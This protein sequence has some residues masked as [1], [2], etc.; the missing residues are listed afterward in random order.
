MNKYNILFEQCATQCVDKHV[1]L[2]PK[3]FQAMK[4]VLSKHASEKL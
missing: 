1:D 2:I 4:T 3:S